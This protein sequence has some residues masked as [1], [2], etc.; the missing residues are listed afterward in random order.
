MIKNAL[1]RFETVLDE[2]HMRGDRARS[3]DVKS[4][5][6]LVISTLVLMLTGLA[7]LLRAS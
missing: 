7:L 1:S 2:G 3:E 6:L 5:V 4:G